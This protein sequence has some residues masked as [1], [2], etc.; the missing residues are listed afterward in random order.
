MFLLTQTTHRMTIQYDPDVGH[1]YT[2]NLRARIPGDDGGYFVVTNSLGFRSDHEFER[3]AS[4]HP[5]ILMFGDSYTAGDDV[6]NAD[7][8][9]DQLGLILGA[10]VQNYGVPGSG[11]DQHLLIYEKFARDVEA[12]L[13]MICVQIDSFHR[14]QVPHRPNPD[15][16]TGNQI[17]VPKPYFEFQN[18]ELVL[19]HVPVPRERPIDQGQMDLE[20][21]KESPRWYD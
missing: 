21:G 17:R 3:A 15:R 6:S 8:Y 10:E 18:G 19:H 14:T 7:R 9:S 4:P 1:R 13:V 2:P 11:T 12:D 5:R 20:A 16:V